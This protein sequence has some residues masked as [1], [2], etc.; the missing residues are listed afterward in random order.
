MT[1]TRRDL[2]E[3]RLR[4]RSFF[5]GVPALMDAA[6]AGSGGEDDP[7]GVVRAKAWRGAL[8][9]VGLAGF[10]YPEAFGGLGDRP[11][12]FAVYAEESR[13]RVPVLES[14]FGL[15][16]SMA[17]PMVRD[18]GSDELRRRMLR[19]GL[20]GDE[21]W[22]QLYSEPNAG[23][24]LASLA[25]KAERDGDEWIVSGQKVWTSGA[26]HADLAILLARTDSAVPKHRGITMFVLPMRQPGVTV[27][28]LRQMTGVS[29]FNEVFLD[30]ARLPSEWIIG[31]LN[32]GW[33]MATALLAHERVSTGTSS[34]SGNRDEKRK[35]GRNPLPAKQLIEL[36]QKVGRSN[37]AVV[38]QRL[39]TTYTGERIMGWLG[40]RRAHPS[41]GKLW[42]TRQGRYA[43]DTAA[44]LQ[45][46]GGIGWEANDV[47]ADYWQYHVLNCRGMSLG[48]GTDEIQR[49]TLGERV[50][51]LPK[52]PVLD[53]DVAYRDLLRN[54]RALGT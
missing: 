38:R 47:E 17:L 16:V 36:A 46:R 28:P 34:V 33:R 8:Y 53:A 24:D 41:I 30:D 22:C 26:Q 43:A 32:D 50:L 5:D 4:V 39:A 44:S 6:A 37:D 51:G 49:N 13:G 23:S 3:F 19:P 15:G 45:F 48:G 25:T 12:E 10:G 14:L 18:Y 31:D 54:S 2:H 9:D 7:R 29:E 21:L 11:E 27:R 20:R 1:S 35:T 42:R 52:E 40:Q